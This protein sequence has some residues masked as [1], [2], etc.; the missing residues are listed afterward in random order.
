MLFK[1][2]IRYSII[3]SIVT[4]IL[5]TMLF[6]CS[7]SLETIEKIPQQDTNAFQTGKNV[8]IAF[9]DSG[10]LKAVLRTPLMKRYKNPQP[11]ML[12]PAGIVVNFYDSLQKRDSY[13]TA[14]FAKRFEQDKKLEL[15]YNVEIHTKDSKSFYSDH[16]IWLEAQKRIYSDQYIK[17]ITPEKIIWGD[18]FESDENFKDYHI[19]KPKGEFYLKN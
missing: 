12:M 18:G 3:K 7:N 14:D 5:V 9:S 15:K 19:I 6:S 10:K 17:I 11:Y 2:I 16:L 1:R 13:M 4:G 8:E